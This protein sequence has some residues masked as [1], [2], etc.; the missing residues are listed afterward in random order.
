MALHVVIGWASLLL[1]VTAA[2]D[3]FAVLGIL[4]V[5][6]AASR[7]YAEFLRLRLYANT[8]L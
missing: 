6:H 2:V 8:Q 5:A 1:S 7:P 3:K 4:G